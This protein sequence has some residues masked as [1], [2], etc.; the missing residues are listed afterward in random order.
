MLSKKLIW[1]R[2]PTWNGHRWRREKHHQSCSGGHQLAGTLSWQVGHLQILRR[3]SFDDGDQLE[4]VIGGRKQNMKEGRRRCRSTLI[5]LCI[6][7][8]PFGVGHFPACLWE[9]CTCTSVVVET[10]ASG[11]IVVVCWIWWLCGPTQPTTRQ[12]TWMR[13]MG[14]ED[15]DSLQDWVS[16]ILSSHLIDYLPR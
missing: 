11:I 4:M 10:G 8:F 7:R 15:S 13:K 6:C 2:W 1:C 9:S 3:S 5:Y 16:F 12:K 14:E